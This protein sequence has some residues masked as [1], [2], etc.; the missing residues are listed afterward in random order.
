MTANVD[1]HTENERNG[2]AKYK[3]RCLAKKLPAKSDLKPGSTHHPSF[4][5]SYNPE[6]SFPRAHKLCQ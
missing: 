6:P 5:C 2:K 4:G 1:A 3:T